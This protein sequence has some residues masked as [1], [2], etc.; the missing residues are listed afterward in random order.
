M[1]M[2]YASVP[3][4]G[5]RATAAG[6]GSASG[7]AGASC[8]GWS[9]ADVG[10]AATTPLLGRSTLEA[11]W[12]N[13]REHAAGPPDYW[14][15]RGVKGSWVR[16]PPSRQ[17][18]TLLA[19]AVRPGQRTLPRL[20]RVVLTRRA[21]GRLGTTWRPHGGMRPVPDAR[22][23][24]RWQLWQFVKTFLSVAAFA[25]TV[26]GAYVGALAVHLLWAFWL[27]VPVAL[28]VAAGRVIYPKVFS[29]VVA[30]RQY[31]G[32]LKLVGSLTAEKEDLERKLTI[33]QSEASDRY[34]VGL[35]EGRAEVTGVVLAALAQA[36]LTIVALK[37]EDGSVL[38][39]ASLSSGTGE[40]K[41]NAIVKSLD[42]EWSLIWLAGLADPSSRP[43]WSK[44]AELA[45]RGSGPPEGLELGVSTLSAGAL[46]AN[47]GALD[48]S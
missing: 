22:N 39:A 3:Q 5:P 30:V 18:E 33:A 40:L 20:Q 14:G 6:C 38:L 16:I 35:S 15:S 7:E 11:T 44:L 26:V 25:A 37:Y 12:A 34:G 9:P 19:R 8:A 4:L 41:G 45:I 24:V 29:L 31:P 43:F 21:L 36:E 32:L 23:G 17:G 10:S 1:R 2:S 42:K 46:E 13:V 47:I 48:E 28:L 27:V